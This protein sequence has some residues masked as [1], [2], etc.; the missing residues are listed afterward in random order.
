ME[1]SRSSSD[2]SAE[3][4]S[5]LAAHER[6]LTGF[7]LALL[8][9][10]ND[11]DEVLQETK[12]RLWDQ[13]DK[14]DPTQSFGG[15]AKS[16]AYYQILTHRKKRKGAQL[17]FS[18]ELISQLADEFDRHGDAQQDRST[19]LQFC[20]GQLS[21][22]YREMLGRFYSGDCKLDEL[23]D[24]MGISIHALRKGMY[25]SRLALHKCITRRLAAAERHP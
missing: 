11:A 14:Y 20:L 10:Y 4:V 13:F 6:Q 9:N 18:S 15:W 16:I 3:F 23:A 12:L 5:L 19:A 22:K 2:R 25:R 21:D 1:A 17:V 8:P 7:V 24:I